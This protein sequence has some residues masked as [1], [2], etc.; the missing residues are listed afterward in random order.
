MSA[1]IVEACAAGRGGGRAVAVAGAKGTGK[2]SFA[3]LLANSLLNH[4]PR[5]A[6][7]DA[8]CGQPE[9]TV[10]GKRPPHAPLC[11]CKLPRKLYRRVEP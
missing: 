11:L 1:A 5:V 6:W 9:F 3:R 4:V 8:D 7:L 10:P 2:S